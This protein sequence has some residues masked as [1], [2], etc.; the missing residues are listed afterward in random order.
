MH[1]FHPILYFKKLIFEI[2]NSIKS[3]SGLVIKNENRCETKMSHS[4]VSNQP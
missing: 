1:F 2:E 3:M 4:R